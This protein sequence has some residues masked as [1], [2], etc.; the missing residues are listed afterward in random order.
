MSEV[1]ITEMSLFNRTVIR[2]DD[3]WKVIKFH[4]Q[5]HSRFRSIK[6][7]MDTL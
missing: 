5:S 2:N 3:F 1:N 4:N 7:R 6:S